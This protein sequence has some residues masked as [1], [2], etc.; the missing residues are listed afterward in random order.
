ML[1]EHGDSGLTIGTSDTRNAKF[2]IRRMVK[3]ARNKRQSLTH[4]SDLNIV[5][6]EV[7]PEIFLGDDGHCAA[8]NSFFNKEITICAQ[9]TNGKE[10][11]TW[12]YAATIRNEASYFAIIEELG[13]NRIDA[14]KQ[15]TNIRIHR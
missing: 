1:R 9:T 11:S 15:M 3:L 8:I 13:T 7:M 2:N 5:D 12:Y 6:W 14:S 4:I 10:E